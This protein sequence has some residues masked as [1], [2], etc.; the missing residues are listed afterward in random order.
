MQNLSL[1]SFCFWA[2]L[3]GSAFAQT[4][5][6]HYSETTGFDHGTRNQSLSLF[7][8]LGATNQFDVVSD[9]SGSEFSSL[10][11]LEQYSVVIF[12]NTSG[13]NLLNASQRA[14]FE[15]YIAG[16]GSYIGIHAAS[17]TYRHSTA[18]GGSTGTWD[19]YAENVSGASVQQSP[20]HTSSNH[21]NDM[22]HSQPGHPLLD[23]IP[24]PWNKTEEYYYWENG[25]LAPGFTELLRVGVTGG[26]SFDEARMMAQFRELPG[27]GR[28][29][30]T[31]LG[32]SRSNFSSDVN[33]Q[34]LLENAV[35]WTID[36]G[37]T[38][39]GD[40]D[41]DG[42][43]DIDDLNSLLAEGPVATGVPATGS[44]PFDLN[45][46]NVIDN[47]DVAQWLNIAAS[48]N[49][50]ASPYK[51]GDANLDGT[52][53]GQDFL[54]WNGAKFT[55]SLAWDD[56]DFNGDG[57]VDGQD[58][59]TWNAQKFTSSDLLTVPEPCQPSTVCA[60]FLIL[61]TI[62]ARQK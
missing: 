16:G 7:E 1:V 43:W 44:E 30:Y 61:M 11:N 59:V 34:R 57:I 35:S 50:L 4:T 18:N 8:S 31:A 29:F 12:S 42:D 46:D 15:A 5:V 21:N 49:G 20:N 2:T 23:G 41:N 22:T 60:I 56:G 54:A 51:N 6:L 36:A 14:N 26:A 9:N 38:S 24:N 53:D 33:F 27:G 13:N 3:T 17:D 47:A 52:V 40:F 10:A 58:F 39:T 55:A 28:A 25:F 62:R 19:W 37:M 45:A 48:E 32:H